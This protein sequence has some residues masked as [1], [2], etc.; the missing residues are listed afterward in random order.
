MWRL[1]KPLHRQLLRRPGRWRPGA[2]AAAA[3]PSAYLRV[4][5]AALPAHLPGRAST[6]R[7]GDAAAAECCRAML[8][9]RQIPLPR[10]L[11]CRP[12]AELVGQAPMAL[13]HKSQWLRRLTSSQ[14][15]F[16]AAARG[17]VLQGAAL[18][19]VAPAAAQRKWAAA[20]RLAHP[21][22][23]L[24]VVASAT[25]HRRQPR[26]Q[27]PAVRFRGACP[28]RLR[29]LPLRLLGRHR[30]PLRLLGLAV[31][32]RRRDQGGSPTLEPNSAWT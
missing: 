10:E 21:P 3:Q 25:G 13:H 22:T 2:A 8:R 31:A 12:L 9:G 7:L 4:A 19:V 14:Y 15:W 20:L 1:M 27:P 24:L 5:A 6:L 18:T 28:L 32:A 29:Q 17:A 11:P 26:L 30:R 16:G 23:V